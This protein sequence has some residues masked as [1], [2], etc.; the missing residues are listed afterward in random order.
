MKYREIKETNRG[1]PADSSLDGTEEAS[2]LGLDA[3][4][5][6]GTEKGTNGTV[7]DRK[8]EEAPVDDDDEDLDFPVYM[9][10][11]MLCK[12]AVRSSL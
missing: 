4:K 8:E 10:Q 2:C 3:A 1:L 7:I 9:W 5:Y 6:D 12:M 11:A